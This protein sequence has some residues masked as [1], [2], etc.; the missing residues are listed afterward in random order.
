MRFKENSLADSGI[1]RGIPSS[2]NEFTYKSVC[3]VKAV[4]SLLFSVLAFVNHLLINKA[5][6]VQMSL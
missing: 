5:N 1:P 6:P 4:H 2:T 3:I